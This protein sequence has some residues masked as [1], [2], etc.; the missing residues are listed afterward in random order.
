ML[1]DDGGPRD[2]GPAAGA[3]REEFVYNHVFPPEATNEQVRAA[4]MLE[5]T[6]ARR[7]GAR[8]QREGLASG[9]QPRG[10]WGAAARPRQGPATRE[11]GA[12]RA[13]AAH[14]R[15]CRE[16]GAGLMGAA[17]MHPLTSTRAARCGGPTLSSRA[18][19]A[20]ARLTCRVARCLTSWWIWTLS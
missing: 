14:T 17:L 11:R 12:I 6:R 7:A 20:A 2:K 18:R 9:W 4:S 10:D 19:T 16:V 1:V 5:L 8:R 15:G 3:S 13:A